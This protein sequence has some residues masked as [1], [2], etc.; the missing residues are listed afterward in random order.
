MSKMGFGTLRVPK[1]I[2]TLKSFALVGAEVGCCVPY[3]FTP[4]GD[5]ESNNGLDLR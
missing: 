2:L 4:S 1:P 5:S 3:A